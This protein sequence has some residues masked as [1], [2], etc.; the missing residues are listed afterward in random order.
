MFLVQTDGHEVILQADG[1]GSMQ[2]IQADNPDVSYVLC[3]AQAVLGLFQ[4]WITCVQGDNICYITS[5]F[6]LFTDV[7]S[8]NTGVTP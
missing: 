7:A 8:C 3:I 1:S 6:S 5:I 4:N 2:I